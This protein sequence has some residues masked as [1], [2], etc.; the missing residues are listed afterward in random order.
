MPAKTAPKPTTKKPPVKERWA[1]IPAAA[2]PSKAASTDDLRP[3]LA[4]GHI[5]HR[6]G[7][8]FL[9]VCDSYVLVELPITIDCPKRE[10]KKLLPEVGLLPHVLKALD[11][12]KTGRFR[13]KDGLVE[14]DGEPALYPVETDY[15]RIKFATLWPDE[16]RKDDPGVAAMGFNPTFM[17]RAAE[18]M[19]VRSRGWKQTAVKARFIS[20][21][22]PVVL[23]PLT[24]DVHGRGLVMPVCLVENN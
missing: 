2:K 18:A 11:R 20:P 12:S 3:V 7:E 13:I 4:M 9:C 15:H 24:N 19:G 23:E 17:H 10:R 22:R 14:I 21:L 8:C 6:G 16:D 1:E 5:E